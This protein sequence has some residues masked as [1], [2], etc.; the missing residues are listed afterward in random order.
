MAGTVT[1]ARRLFGVGDGQASVNAY[2]ALIGV[3]GLVGWGLT[4]AV[5]S[6]VT[7]DVRLIG[8]TGIVL[9]GW[10]VL[11]GGRLL[12]GGLN[13]P[14]AESLS[15]PFL[16]WLVLI[17]GAFAANLY[18]A[19]V[20][21]GDLAGLLMGAPWLVAMTVGYLATGLLVTRGGVFLAAG[22]VGAALVAALVVVGPLPALPV[23][24]GLLHAVPM[25][26]DAARG[27]RELTASGRPRVATGRGDPLSVTVDP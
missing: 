1:Q 2:L 5:V 25:F 24:L 4:T 8:W 6:L 18:G 27:G 26:V 7:V 15:A 13:V 11:T 9:L 14:R 21:T 10:V 19:T 17:V 22:V 23:I 3:V 12:L 16:V 20:A